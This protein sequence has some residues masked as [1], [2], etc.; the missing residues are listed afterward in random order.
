MFEIWPAWAGERQQDASGAPP[1][2]D[3]DAQT[4]NGRDGGR[5]REDESV[6]RRDEGEYTNDPSTK[7]TGAQLST[8]RLVE[9]SVNGVAIHGRSLNIEQG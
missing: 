6:S 9:Q 4:R 5:H 8:W 7:R 3:G 2:D 1:A